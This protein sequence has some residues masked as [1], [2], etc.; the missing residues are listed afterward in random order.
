MIKRCSGN[1]SFNLKPHYTNKINFHK[2]KTSK[3][4]LQGTCKI[5]KKIVNDNW[6]PIVNHKA[7][8]T[9]LRKLWNSQRDLSKYT[10]S[11]ARLRFRYKQNSPNWLTKDHKKKIKEFY[12]LRNKLNKDTGI[13]HHV[14]HIV[15]IQGKLV[16]GLHV[17]WNLQVITAEENLRKKNKYES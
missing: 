11:Y 16:S 15:P 2:N 3:D 5:C 1:A 7:N 14:D 12:D 6:N 10:E 13:L 4:G 8:I 9:G 17:P